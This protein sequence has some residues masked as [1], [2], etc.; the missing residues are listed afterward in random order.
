MEKDFEGTI[1]R[2]AATGYR[3][4]EFA[5]YFGRSPRDVRALLDQHGLSAPSSHVSLAPEQWRGAGGAAPVGG[6]R[7]LAVARVPGGG[8][9]PPRGDKRAGGRLTRAAPAAQAPGR[10]RCR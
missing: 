10:R 8:G 9:A 6:P 1:A 2:V 7:H 5:G 3:E 4:V